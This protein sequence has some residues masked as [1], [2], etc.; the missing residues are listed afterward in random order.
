[1]K[2]LSYWIATLVTPPIQQHHDFTI[3]STQQYTANVSP[4]QKGIF[5]W[6]ADSNTAPSAD[7]ID[8][9]KQAFAAFYNTQNLDL[10]E[11]LLT[12]AIQRWQAQPADEL[13]G[14][15]RVRGD[16]YTQREEAE[17]AVADYTQA[18]QLLEGNEQA[19]PIELPRSILGRARALKSLKKGELAATDYE[20]ALKLFSTE[21]SE[22]TD[23]ELVQDGILKN[24]YAAWEWGTSLRMKGDWT[25]AAT[26]HALSADA[27]E[28]IGDRPHFL[29]SQ[30]DYGIDLAASNQN[31]KAEQV[32]KDIIPKT[33]GVEAR[34]VALLQR[35]IAKEGEGRMA[36]ASLLWED[37]NRVEAEQYLGDAC[38]RLDQMQAD[39]IAR[40]QK[41][42]IG[43]DPATAKGLL[44]SIDDSIAAMDMTCSRFRKE[45]FLE[46]QL[47]W[48]QT[49]RDK[50]IR[51][52]NLQ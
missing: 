4:L 18:I 5:T 20:Q 30:I 32:L 12:Q 3:S 39:A 17:K 37:G 11:Q 45:S 1:M 2:F 40:L 19:D 47:G 31:E 52:E 15:Y 10:S 9:L 34:D 33:T 14:L 23:A 25:G 42:S 48:P 50:V 26:V 16:C 41:E 27:F 13:A 46:E 7:D 51:L 49:L 8:V 28:Q 38:L 35:V 21:R 36:L 22:A 6:L 24:P 29:I 44:Y 43:T